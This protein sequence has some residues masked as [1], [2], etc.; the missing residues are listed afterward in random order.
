VKMFPP[1]FLSDVSMEK[2]SFLS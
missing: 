2:N 1:V